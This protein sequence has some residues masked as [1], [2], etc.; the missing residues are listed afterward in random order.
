MVDQ[1]TELHP[2]MQYF[3]IGANEVI[4]YGVCL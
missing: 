3:H 4:Y 1:I 2:A